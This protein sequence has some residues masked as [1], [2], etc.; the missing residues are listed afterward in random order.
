[1]MYI[2]SD[3]GGFELK[4]QLVSW[5]DAQK[6]SVTDLGP[7][8]LNPL[9]DYPVISRLVAERV[10]QHSDNLGILICRSGQGVSIVANKVPGIRAALACD[11]AAAVHAREDDHANILCLAGD[12]LDPTETIE[13]TKAWLAAT[14]KMESKYLRR[15][16]EILAIEKMS[17]RK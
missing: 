2:G 12:R 13:I 1:M 6:I 11:V 15:L 9:D 5:F 8:Q 4:N 17:Q 3:H 16:A 10:T 7:R 14:P